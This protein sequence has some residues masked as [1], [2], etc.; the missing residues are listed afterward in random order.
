MASNQR[1]L[2][3]R[4]RIPAYAVIVRFAVVLQYLRQTG[5]NLRHAVGLKTS[6]REELIVISWDRYCVARRGSDG[7]F[8]RRGEGEL[9]YSSSI[10][11]DDLS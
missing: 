9:E 10:G 4:D 3:W 11:R 2:A 5:L 6:R 1:M 7:V 8:E